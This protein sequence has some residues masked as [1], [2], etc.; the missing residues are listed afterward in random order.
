VRAK[1]FSQ[2]HAANMPVRAGKLC[3]MTTDD[4]PL[5]CDRCSTRLVPGKGNFFVV[6]IEAVADPSPPD[7]DEEELDKDLR[8]EIGELVEEMRGLSQQELMDQVYRRVT[9]YLC[10]SCYAQ[11]IENPAG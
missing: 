7:I 6:Q 1:T 9:I 8:R 5:F 4:S 3:G 11:W 2:W 10:L